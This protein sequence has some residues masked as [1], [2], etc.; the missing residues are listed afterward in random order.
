MRTRRVR[1][2]MAPV[3]SLMLAASVAA[4]SPSPGVARDRTLAPPVHP[5]PIGVLPSDLIAIAT[6]TTGAGRQVPV[7]IGVAD[8]GARRDVTRLVTTLGGRLLAVGGTALEASV[9]A[10]SLAALGTDARVRRV[11]SLAEPLW[12]PATSRVAQT[13]GANLWTEA[14]VGGAGVRIGVIDQ[15]EGIEK[16]LGTAIPNPVHVRCWSSW[17]GGPSSIRATVDACEDEW[18][19]PHGVAVAE[20]IASIAPEADLYLAEPYTYLQVMDAIDWFAAEGVRIVNA[21][22]AAAATF[23]GPGDGSY[24][25]EDLTFYA[26]VDHAVSHGMLWVNAAGNEDHGVYEAVF[27]GG[28][29]NT[30]LHDFATGADTDRIWLDEDESAYIALRWDDSWVKPKTDLDLVL[31]SPDGVVDVADS[32]DT[33][34]ETGEPVEWLVYEAEASGW[35]R[36]GISR[37]DG[38][39]ARFELN[40]SSTLEFRTDSA[41][42]SSPVDT[43][44]PGAIVAGAVRVGAPDFVEWFSSHGPT[45][46][47]RQ[48]PDV[49]APDCG[50]TVTYDPFC[51][52]SQSAPSTVGVA[53]LLLA[54]DPGLADPA[55]LADAIRASTVPVPQAEIREVGAGLVHLGP[56]PVAVPTPPERSELTIALPPKPVA[57]GTRVTARVTGPAVAEGRHAVVEAWRDGAWTKVVS[58]T[59]RADGTAA[60][61]WTAARNDLL[62]AA[63]V[64]EEGLPDG[65]S[66]PGSLRVIARISVTADPPGRNIAANT[67]VRYTVTVAPAS[68]ATRFTP[69]RGP[70]ATVEVR[71]GNEWRQVSSGLAAT[72]GR[73][74]TWTFD[75]RWTRG[76]WRIRF[77]WAAWGDPEVWPVE[78]AWMQVNAK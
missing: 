44:S 13:V 11:R 31:Y 15:F 26:F 69:S 4:A 8:A 58:G 10:G 33:N 47:G 3:V 25:E 78:S 53:A 28:A 21:S 38:P 27:D 65:E 40:A 71:F 6:D 17:S 48:K 56:P 77:W 1:R 2:V 34:A 50:T 30:A 62:R 61:S 54:A 63:L 42:L 57:Y 29:G 68:P 16:L 73:G 14:A 55:K 7:S 74:A 24:D 70:T 36:I 9:P 18:T 23:E 49:V 43:R 67:V 75:V 37:W 5:D 76:L 66:E 60:L 64:R 45:R 20:T 51:G 46:D 39:P 12:R 35:Y 32:T 22:F 19:G 52:T 41:S 59:V 72:A